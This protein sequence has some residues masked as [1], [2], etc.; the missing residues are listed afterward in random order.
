[1]EPSLSIA[2]VSMAESG[3]RP[4]KTAAMVRE[5]A[6][7]LELD[8][9]A[10]V[11][12][13]WAMQ[14][15]VDVVDWDT[16]RTHNVWWGELRPK[17]EAETEHTFAEQR[18]AK[19]WTPE[20]EYKAPRLRTFALAA[21]ICEVLRRLLGNNWDIRYRSEEDFHDPIERRRPRIVI[22]IRTAITGDSNASP[23]NRLLATFQCP[24]PVS[25]P[26]VPET[27]ARPQS[28]SLAPDVAWILKSVVA[29]P[30]RDRASVAG[31]IHGLREGARL[32]SESSESS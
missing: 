21:E 30:S 6:K 18:A 3:N 31:F 1:M 8:D 11:E 15:L 25:R 9:D 22:E 16:E 13:W 28:D 20:E 10:M 29:M 27:T 5:Y 17:A 19:L 2:G 4:P 24:E 7:A 14:G 12:L 23:S 26:S 32:F